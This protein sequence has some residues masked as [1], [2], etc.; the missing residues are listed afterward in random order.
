[1]DSDDQQYTVLINEEEQ[2]CLWPEAVE[3]PDGWT[4]VGPKGTKD[5]CSAYVNEHWTDMTPKSQR[6]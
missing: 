5:A 4:Q 6:A 1:M 2:Y 3:V